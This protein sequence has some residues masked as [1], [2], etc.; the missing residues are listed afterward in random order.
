M[1]RQYRST[2]NLSDVKEFLRKTKDKTR[3][4]FHRSQETM[5]V[6]LPACQLSPHC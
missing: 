1:A 4:A 2:A 5:S 3:H 6:F